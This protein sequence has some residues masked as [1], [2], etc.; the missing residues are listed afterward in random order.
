MPSGENQGLLY[1]DKTLV[2]AVLF[3]KLVM[4]TGLN[5][6]AF[7]HDAYYVGVLYGRSAACEQ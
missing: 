6:A 2:K 3:D 5:N 4:G 1:V 7:M